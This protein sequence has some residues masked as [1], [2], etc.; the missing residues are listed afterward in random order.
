[1]TNLRA[2]RTLN[3]YETQ[4]VQALA[5]LIK[6][7]ADFQHGVIQKTT[8]ELEQARCIAVLGSRFMT[9]VDL[10]LEAR[11]WDASQIN[12]LAAPGKR[13]EVVELYDATNRRIDVAA[14]KRVLRSMR[15]S[16]EDLAT[17]IRVATE[18]LTVSVAV[19]DPEDTDPKA[20]TSTRDD[21]TVVDF[22]SYVLESLNEGNTHRIPPKTFDELLAGPARLR[23][24]RVLPA[25]RRAADR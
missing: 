16:P 23:H 4:Q 15:N 13:T 22:Q 24:P 19:K 11:D 5:D 8:F 17:F 14:A 7:A 10:E 6:I 12:A 2:A 25:S 18:A 21:S 3:P 9:Q 20:A 1:M